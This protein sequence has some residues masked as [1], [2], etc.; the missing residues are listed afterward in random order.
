MNRRSW[1]F[2][3]CVAVILAT[4]CSRKPSRPQLT[5]EIPAGFSGNFSLQM[6][7]KDASPLE[8]QGDTYVVTVPRSGAVV[9]STLLNKPNVTFKNAT[10]GSVWGYS[11]ST[12]TTGD[13]L[14]VG[15][16]IE[17]FVGTRK[18]F[19]AEQGRK[20][21]SGAFKAQEIVIAGA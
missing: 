17:F 18:E 14:S 1:A 12:Y 5:V 8:K 7:S 6:G 19:E 15:A 16:K 13:G 11:E 9:T 2:L 20:N 4:A 3:L 10:D 21:H